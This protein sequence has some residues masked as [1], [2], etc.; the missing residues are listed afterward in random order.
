MTV[1]VL[2][3]SGQPTQKQ[4]AGESYRRRLLRDLC[5]KIV[6]TIVISTSAAA[7]GCQ[8]K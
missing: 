3:G 2:D 8:L 6:S 1:F 4:G 5:N 7:M